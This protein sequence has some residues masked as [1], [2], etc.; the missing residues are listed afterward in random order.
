LD[1]AYV[2]VGA[3]GKDR[4]KGEIVSLAMNYAAQ[5]PGEHASPLPAS[6]TIKLVGDTALVRHHG[7]KDISM[8]LF[9]FVGGHWRALYSQHT[10]IAPAT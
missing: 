1:T 3:A 9:V 4:T 8:D 7:D 6:S 10:A 2:S 5:H